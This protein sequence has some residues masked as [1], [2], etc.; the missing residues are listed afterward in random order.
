M[1]KI[2]KKIVSLVTMAAFALTLVPAAAFAAP[3][4]TDGFEIALTSGVESEDVYLNSA[5]EASVDLTVELKGKA[6]AEAG[7]YGQIGF[8]AAFKDTKIP[9][10]GVDFT[11]DSVALNDYSDAYSNGN[12]VFLTGDGTTTTGT[13]T[14]TVGFDRDE[15]GQSYD[16]YA[17]VFTS[18]MTGADNTETASKMVANAVEV[19][20]INVKISNASAT[21]ASSLVIDG[22][23]S[24]VATI[25][26][27]EAEPFYFDVRTNDGAQTNDP[28]VAPIYVWVEDANGNVVKDAVI[29]KDGNAL[30]PVDGISTITN[31]VYDNDTFTVMI[32]TV[33]EGYSLHAS[34]ENTAP[35]VD[36][37]L[38]S[39]SINVTEKT[40]TTEYLEVTD[41]EGSTAG[42][43]PDN[44]VN[45]TNENEEANT[46]YW[47]VTMD[48]NVTPNDLKEY[49]VEGTAWADVAN[50]IPAENE[51]LTITTQ[52]ANLTIN[53]A[54]GKVKTDADG[55]FE[56]TFS[57]KDTGTGYITIYEPNDQEYAVLKVTQNAMAPV[58][59]ETVKDGGIM[60][61]GT[62][63]QYIYNQVGLMTEAV[64]FNI[65]DAYDR[66]A[67]GP[68]VIDSE[69]AALNASTNPEHN[70]FID[71]VAPEG[72]SLKDEDINLAWDPENAVYTLEYVGKDAVH[73][74]IPGEYTVTVSLNNGKD[75]TA[76]FTLAEFQ[77]AES[78]DISM[79]AEAS[80]STIR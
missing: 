59:I 33:G 52:N 54:D 29:S 55:N 66:D 39:V 19:G 45:G 65:T 62:D 23:H 15:A 27:G 28:L 12:I 61:A 56:F 72:S 50:Q 42:V 17:F 32:P 26:K 67:Y 60:L 80:L 77:G 10:S 8:F 57:I 49:T 22:S 30:T 5:N 6:I 7:E 69:K 63:D 2:S 58:D 79:T 34:A 75:A 38:T 35:N 70:D 1:N 13:E 47:T 73:D 43:R 53:D 78:L 11:N 68:E 71:V 46:T 21:R 37:Q 16:I 40:F 25:E 41:V 20:T 31:D 36:T 48:D 3:V 9:A 64:Q 74:L 44:I 18:D 4:G 24:G 14:V 51:E 76:T